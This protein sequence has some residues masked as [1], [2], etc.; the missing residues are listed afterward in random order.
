MTTTI[1]SDSSKTIGIT[2]FIF[3]EK[4]ESKELLNIIESAGA[5]FVH[6]DQGIRDLS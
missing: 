5:H 4:K 1:L 3:A 6:I 2:W